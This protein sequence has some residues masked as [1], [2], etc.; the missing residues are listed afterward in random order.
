VKQSLLKQNSPQKEN[1]SRGFTLVELVIAVTVVAVVTVAVVVGVSDIN[2]NTQLSNAASR[3][4][5]D[6]R[7]AHELAM[8]NRREVDFIVNVGSNR[9]EIRW[10]DDGT[11]VPSPYG[12]GDAATQ[13]GTGQ[14]SDITITS[15]QLSTRLS[16]DAYGAPMSGG[17]TF[18][19]QLSIMLLNSRVHVGV[20]SSGYTGLEEVSGGGC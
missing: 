6:V 19:E 20:L 7:Y 12:S 8:A 14:F 2:S 16:F 9:Y 10:H 11:Y 18:S 4:L 3:A 15:S 13:F 17:A 1:L 5:A